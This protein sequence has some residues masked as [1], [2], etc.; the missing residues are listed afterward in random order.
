MKGFSKRMEET[1]NYPNHIFNSIP[2]DE[3]DC[4][5]VE[6]VPNLGDAQDE[7]LTVSFLKTMAN[8]NE[9]HQ[10]RI[11]REGRG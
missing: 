2:M 5:T 9:Y 7:L 8:R 10:K 3:F 1:M 4:V 11:E 6:Q